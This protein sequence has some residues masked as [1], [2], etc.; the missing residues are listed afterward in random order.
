ME[1]IDPFD[2]FPNPIRE[3]R[4]QQK[5][6]EKKVFTD[7]NA[8]VDLAFLLLTFFMLTTTMIK[9]K[10]MEVV[11]PV[12]S[13]DETKNDVQPVK[14]SRALSLIPLPENRLCMYKGLSAE[15]VEELSYTVDGLRAALQELLPTIDKP[16]IIIKPHPESNYKNLVDLLDEMNVLDVERYAID[17]YSDSD[18]LILK[19]AG[20][21][22][23]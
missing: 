1:P 3:G 15:S 12:P 23:L 14:E 11:M 21:N 9:P 20:I 17:D 19:D 5:V 7:M 6:S 8:M 16:I 2:E 22:N 4:K 13:Q 18:R 10:V